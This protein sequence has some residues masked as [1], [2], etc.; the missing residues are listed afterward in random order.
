[1][2]SSPERSI[3]PGLR[4]LRRLSEVNRP[5][6]GANGMLIDPP[7]LDRP[8]TTY[9]RW[10]SDVYP[11]SPVEASAMYLPIPSLPSPGLELDSE[12]SSLSSNAAEQPSSNLSH[13]HSHP[14]S[15]ERSLS[16]QSPLRRRL[17]SMSS[18]ICREV[19]SPDPPTSSVSREIDPESFAPG[20]FRNT[21]Q[22]LWG[23]RNRTHS[24]D[25]RSHNTAIGPQAHVTPPSLPPLAF[26]IENGHSGV[27]RS[28]RPDSG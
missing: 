6:R 18:R 22:S 3:P 2:E 10:T 11:P 16:P 15:T 24:S 17:S 13:I 12:I 9:R 19:S 5:E 7:S 14:V 25:P 4:F 28:D 27:Q 20:P 8:E 1:N 23:P 26:E 21:I